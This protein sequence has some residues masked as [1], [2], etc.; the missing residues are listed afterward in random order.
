MSSKSLSRHLWLVA[1]VIFL[2]AG[3]IG[4]KSLSQPDKL[5]E[6]PPQPTATIATLTTPQ[7][8]SKPQATPTPEP[9]PASSVKQIGDEMW[10]VHLTNRDS[11]YDTG[12][13][14]ITLCCVDAKSSDRNSD[15]KWLLKIKGRTFFSRDNSDGSVHF[16]WQEGTEFAG[17]PIDPDFRDTIKMKLDDESTA[18]T[19]VILFT[20]RTNCAGSFDIS[21]TDE[22]HHKLHKGAEAWFAAKKAQIA[23][24]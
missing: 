20:I 6:S 11:W 22:Q 19:A 8:V 17:R 2:V 14:V 12:L 5:V 13:P 4:I 1:A 9:T 7:P 24:R 23:R 10:Q 15:A 21:E 3:I 18:Q 16:H